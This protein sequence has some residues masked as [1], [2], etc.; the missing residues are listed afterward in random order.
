M[1][2]SLIALLLNQVATARSKCN[3][4]RDCNF[5]S[6]TRKQIDR[7]STETGH[8]MIMKNGGVHSL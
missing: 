4:K 6:N 7:F 5:T 2:K 8:K 1:A 3:F